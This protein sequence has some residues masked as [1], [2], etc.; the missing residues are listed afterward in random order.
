MG[1]EIFME[2]IM[3]ELRQSYSS[4]WKGFLYDDALLTC[5]WRS[6]ALQSITTPRGIQRIVRP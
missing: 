2:W 3:A 6:R 1:L 4:L 5:S